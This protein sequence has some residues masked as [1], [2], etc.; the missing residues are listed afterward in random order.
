MKAFALVFL[1]PLLFLNS[2]FIY[3]EQE[4]ALVKKIN[5][6]E[7]LKV[8]RDEMKK[9]SEG[10]SLGIWVL[11]DQVV[12]AKQARIIGELYLAHIDGMKSPFNIWHSSW[13]ISNLYR[14]GD[15]SVKA[16][17]ETAYQKAKKQPE[18]LEGN[19]RKIAE[20]HINGGLTTGF[21]HLGGLYYAHTH[22]VAPGNKWFLQSYEQYRR[23]EEKDE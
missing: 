8:A 3:S 9:T 2:C 21:I 4:P 1:F 10:G 20:S 11:R 19:I 14:L 6:D 16:E 22:V 12:T 13:A 17:L 23:G 18:R 5:V 15:D 7:T